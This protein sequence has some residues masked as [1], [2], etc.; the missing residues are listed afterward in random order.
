[1]GRPLEFDDTVER[2]SALEYALG[3]LASE[4]AN[5]LRVF[6]WRRRIDIDH[7]E[8]VIVGEVDHALSYLEV[9]GEEGRPALAGV[10]LKLFFAAPDEAGVHALWTQLLDRLPLLATIRRACPVDVEL[11]VT[12]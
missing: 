8:A 4:V 6:A 1:M 11:I 10:H 5:G 7:V 9:V 12:P 2:I 3:A